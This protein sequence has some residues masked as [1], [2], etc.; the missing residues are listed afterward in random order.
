[1]KQVALLVATCLFSFAA[2]PAPADPAA[3]TSAD[4]PM[5]TILT[6]TGVSVSVTFQGDYGPNRIEGLLV[7]L[8]NE[9]IR[10]REGKEVR[11]IELRHLQELQRT[12]LGV[13][14]DALSTYSLQMSTGESYILQP[15]KSETPSGP[16]PATI[17]RTM[18]V[19][20]VPK[21]AVALKTELFGVLN[22][23]FPKL[24]Q[25]TVQPIR[26][27]LREV[28]NLSLPVEVLPGLTLRVPF[29]RLTNF[30][31]DPMG[32]TT[33][34]SFGTAEGVTGRVKQMPEGGLVVLTTDGVE[35]HIPLSDVVQY[36]LEGPLNVAGNPAA[37][38]T[39]GR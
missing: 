3:R 19:V 27:T 29:Q 21:D 1:M 22:I 4:A 7:S 9:P 20:S 39:A 14:P 5:V 33:T 35:R 8:P 2:V 6:A 17:T 18:Q 31:R 28:P 32:G 23:P 24:L 34:V 37:R 25:L 11:E 36:N 26:G 30:H 10:A 16:Q 15:D 12:P 38:D 13:G